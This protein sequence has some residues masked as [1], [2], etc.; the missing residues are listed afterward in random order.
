[1][2]EARLA[3]AVARLDQHRELHLPLRR[4]DLLGRLAMR[5]LWRRQLKWQVETNLAARDAV[6]SLRDLVLEQRGRVEHVAGAVEGGAL[7]SADALRHEIEV[8]RAA[9]Q[10][11][12]SGINQRLYAAIGSV[13]SE[14]SD[15]RLRLA[16]KAEDSLDV[17]KRLAALEDGLRDLAAAAQDARV[18]HAQVD[19]FLD[20]VRAALPD[21]PDGA[22]LAAL[23]DRADNLELAVVELLDGPEDRVREKRAVHLDDVRATGGPVFDAAPGR[24]EWLDI[25]R[26]A[27]VP[28]SGASANPAVV[29]RCAQSGLDVRHVDPLTALS[30]VEPRTLGAVTAFRFAERLAP[31]DLARFAALAARALRP[32]GVLVV[33]TA[34]DGDD[35]HL[36]PFA[37]RPVHPTYLRFLISAQGFADV[38]TEAG[39]G[40]YTVLARR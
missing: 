34:A 19:L 29:R 8:L 32:G 5:V 10:N 6:A 14:L 31:G 25:L 22:K 35:F 18:R 12:M 9:D 40:R 4:G 2:S 15:L 7:A 26:T 1:M 37:V 33:E 38:C 13:R 24:G 36:D 39:D 27:Q 3:D 17:G 21:A 20:E 16:E 23:P 28:A 30:E 11:M